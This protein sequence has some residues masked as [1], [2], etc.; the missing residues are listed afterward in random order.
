MIKVKQLVVLEEEKHILVLKIRLM[1][2][3]EY[4]KYKEIMPAMYKRWYLMDPAPYSHNIRYVLEDGKIADCTAHNVLGI[5]PVIEFFDG[6]HTSPR[7]GE[8]QLIIGG[9]PFTVFTESVDYRGIAVC[10]TLL[11][12]HAFREHEPYT[13]WPV[14]GQLYEASDAKRVIDIWAE[15]N[16]IEVEDD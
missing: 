3:W 12:N 2:A 11:C 16:G 5:R 9:L 4:E 1:Y 8:D 15:D 13:P 6:N 7:S 14:D 10:D